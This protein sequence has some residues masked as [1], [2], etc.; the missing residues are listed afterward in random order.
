MSE[1]ASRLTVKV[2]LEPKPLHELADS[3]GVAKA[4]LSPRRVA[5]AALLLATLLAG[6]WWVLTGGWAQGFGPAAAPAA[7]QH[8]SS[9]PADRSSQRDSASEHDSSPEPAAVPQAVAVTQQPAHLASATANGKAGAAAASGAVA[10]TAGDNLASGTLASGTLAGDTL[11]TKAVP[12]NTA[13]HSPAIAAPP[14]YPTGFSRIVLTAHMRNLEPGAPA[15][16]QVPY[17]AI[18]RLYLFTE[19]KGYAGEVLQHRWY[20]QNQLKTTATLTIEDSPWRTYSENWLLDD[21]QGPWRVEIVDQSQK[22]LFE[23]SFTYQ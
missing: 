2:R 5:A 14:A 8:D 1:Q 4:P 12:D 20:H 10:K 7:P 3:A 6:I 13:P 16:P 22:V 23:Y 11:P 21:Q 9:S 18:K 15:G 19:L 17:P